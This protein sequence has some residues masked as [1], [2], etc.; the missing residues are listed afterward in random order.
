[1]A[2]ASATKVITGKVRLSYAFLFKPRSRPNAKEGEEPKYSTA[3]L[4]PKNTPEGKATYKK[5]RAAQQAALEEGKSKLGGVIPK[6]WKDTIHDGDE[7]ADLD[8]NP[9]YAGH[10]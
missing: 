2:Q 7:D 3:L 10:W 5:L 8:N 1:M 4:I 6:K 9:E